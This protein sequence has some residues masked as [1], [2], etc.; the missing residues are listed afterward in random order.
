MNDRKGERTKGDKKGMKYEKAMQE[1]FSEVFR[2]LREIEKDTKM[3]RIK[4]DLEKMTGSAPA[5]SLRETT[6][7]F[8]QSKE[9][10]RKSVPSLPPGKS[11]LPRKLTRELHS[12]LPP[13]PGLST[14]QWVLTCSEE[15]ESM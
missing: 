13:N 6:A 11:S 2:N 7:A 14:M 9:L 3:R 8:V 4:V 5:A 15:E 1:A 10:T 12:T